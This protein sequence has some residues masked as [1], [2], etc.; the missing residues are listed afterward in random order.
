MASDDFYRIVDQNLIANESD[1][2]F[3]LNTFMK[4]ELVRRGQAGE[5]KPG[6]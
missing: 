6:A 4:A 5:D 2:V 1:H 3:T